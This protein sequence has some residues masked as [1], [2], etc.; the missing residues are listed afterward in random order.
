MNET[1]NTYNL[2]TSILSA[3]TGLDAIKRA[4]ITDKNTGIK[5]LRIQDVS[6]RKEFKNWGFCH[7]S[8]EN[9]KK[10]ALRKGEI[11]IARTGNTIGVNQFINGDLNS[12]FNNGLIRLRLDEKLFFPKYIYYNLRSLNFKNHISSIAYGTSTQ[13]NMQINSLLDFK[14]KAPPLPE[15]RAIASILS[16]LDDKIELNLQTNKTLEEMAMALYKHWFVDFGPFKEGKFI[17]SELG[18]IPE[19]WEVKRIG[20]VASIMG[21]YAF[22]SKLFVEN[23]IKV[24][25]IKNISNNVTSI[26]N[27]DCISSEESKK[28]N[29]KFKVFKGDFL[30]AM[31]GAEVGKI[32]VVPE[33]CQDLFLNQ[34]VCKIVDKEI[35]N[36][37][38]FIG[39]ILQS[40]KYYSIIQNLAYGSAQPNISTTDLES[41]EIILPQNVMIIKDFIK[42]LK[43]II[44]KIIENYSENVIL[45]SQRDSLLPKLISGEIRVK[46]LETLQNV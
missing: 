23:G 22:K 20:Q 13:P 24:I 2:K 1:F 45:K 21:G 42:K 3:N 41:I 44:D 27:T 40:T 5:C 19:G 16:A 15:Q 17:D 10:F 46:D 38:V 29:N 18:I 25:K 8:N 34:R 6:Q 33:Y 26:E 4:P 7:V 32:G 37:S 31:T 43:V 9:F 11:I 30:I 39:F 12:V 36:I 28:I 14:F 35:N